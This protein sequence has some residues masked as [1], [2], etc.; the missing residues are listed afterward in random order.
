MRTFRGVLMR[1]RHIRYRNRYIL[2]TY[3]YAVTYVMDIVGDGSSFCC[4]KIWKLPA[5]YASPVRRGDRNDFIVPGVANGFIGPFSGS[6]AEY[7]SIY[8]VDAAT[9]HSRYLTR[10]PIFPQNREINIGFVSLPG[11][12]FTDL[13]IFFPPKKKTSGFISRYRMNL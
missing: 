4:D 6:F 9:N 3:T 5:S 11:E 10:T 13:H 8:P 7:L 1:K 2:P 12:S